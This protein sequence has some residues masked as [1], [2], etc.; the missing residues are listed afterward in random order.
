MMAAILDESI[1]E[2]ERGSLDR[3]I[4]SLLKSRIQVTDELSIVS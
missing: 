3:L 4:R 2:E 1:S